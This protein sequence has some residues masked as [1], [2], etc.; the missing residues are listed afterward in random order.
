MEMKAIGILTSGGDAPGMNAAYRSVAK[1]ALNKGIKVYGIKRGYNG[2]LN[3]DI[4]ELNA[5]SVLSLIHRSGTALYTARCLEFKEEEGI[6]KAIRTCK[7]YEIDGCVVIG[8]DGSFRGA[9][10]LSLRGVP[11]IGI[12]ATID[13]DISST[14]YAIGFDTALNTAVDMIDKIRDTSESH[15]RCTVVEVMGNKSGYLA[16]NS[17]LAVGATAIVMHEVPCEVER[18]VVKR[19]MEAKAKGKHHFIII[20]AE[21]TLPVDQLAKQIEAI[22]GIES[23]FSILGHVQRGGSPSAFDRILASKMGNHAV[24]LLTQG[25]GNRVVACRDMKIVN[26]DIYEALNIVKPI[27]M[28][29]YNLALEIGS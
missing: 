9:R 14:D 6:Q 28:N 29:L 21:K 4:I 24:E 27:D 23:R 2:L 1:C 15:D 12:P 11:C 26:Y 20:V 22:T 18:D 17:G 8:G 16:L 13:N 7:E 5:R 19:I 10:D 3:G 25:T